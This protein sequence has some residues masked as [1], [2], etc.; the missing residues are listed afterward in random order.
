MSPSHCHL[1]YGSTTNSKLHSPS[2]VSGPSLCSLAALSDL[3]LLDQ[4]SDSSYDIAFCIKTSSEKIRYCQLAL[5]KCRHVY[6]LH[7]SASLT[8]VR[9][10]SQQIFS[11]SSTVSAQTAA[12]VPP[13]SDNRLTFI[14]P[15]VCNVYSF[16]VGKFLMSLVFQP[17]SQTALP[18][19]ESSAPFS[20]PDLA[21]LNIGYATSF[22]SSNVGNF[23]LYLLFQ[24]ISR[25]A[26]L[27]MHVRSCIDQK[28]DVPVEVLEAL[29]VELQAQLDQ[30]ATQFT[31]LN[32][33]INGICGIIADTDALPS[34]NASGLQVRNIAPAPE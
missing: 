32:T 5:H 29:R 27:I 17:P 34:N 9:G 16:N 10:K 12:R 7:R 26:L 24:T 3:H 22:H 19:T 1:Y 2:G 33:T 18:P 31:E 25:A 15:W 14:D 28:R 23:L 30:I 20:A 21:L 6:L 13:P 8:T 4:D 11:T